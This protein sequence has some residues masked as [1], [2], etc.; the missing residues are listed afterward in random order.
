[1]GSTFAD[2][3]YTFGRYYLN[4]FGWAV[5]FNITIGADLK[6]VYQNMVDNVVRP[7]SRAIL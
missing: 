4:Q 7:A 6:V 5:D 3:I 2:I 1:M